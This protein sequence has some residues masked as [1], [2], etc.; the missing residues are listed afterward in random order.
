MQGSYGIL[1]Q[2]VWMDYVDVIVL[3]TL[4]F[5]FFLILNLLQ[6]AL[7]IARVLL[8]FSLHDRFE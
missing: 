7:F 8:C 6:A 3:V 4:A 2:Y 5:S 1:D